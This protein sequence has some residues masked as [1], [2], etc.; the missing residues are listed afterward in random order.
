MLDCAQQDSYCLHEVAVHV[1]SYHLERGKDYNEANLGLG[2]KMKAPASRWF[3]AAGGYQN[4]LYRTSLY[5]GV[6]T[7]L[8]KT[9]PLALRLT[10]GVV[11]GYNIPVAPALLPELVFSVRGFGASIGYMPKMT[12]GDQTVDSVISF[13]LLKRF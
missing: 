12:F 3:V 7:D 11:T 10:A 1:A 2:L 5:A 6:G 8:P 4:S 13:S 9:G